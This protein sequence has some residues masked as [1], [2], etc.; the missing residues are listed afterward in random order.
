[1][2]AIAAQPTAT[3]AMMT[4]ESKTE[5]VAPKAT[6]KPEKKPAE[7]IKPKPETKKPE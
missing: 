2:D 4:E 1:M 3:S 5:I 6:A 7:V